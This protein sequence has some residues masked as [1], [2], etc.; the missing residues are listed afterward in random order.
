MATELLSAPSVGLPSPAARPPN[1]HLR[2]HVVIERAAARV[3]TA[4]ETVFA[5]AGVFLLSH[6]L[7]PLL[8]EASG[9]LGGAYEG[10]SVLRNQFAAI[11]AMSLLLLAVHAKDSIATLGR[12]PE[13]AALV[14]LALASTQWSAAPDITL[15]RAFA[16]LG[17]TAFG[18][19]LASRFTPRALLRVLAAAFGLIALAS[20]AFAIGVPALGV[21]HGTHAG[22]WKGVYTHKNSLGSAMVVGGLVFLLLRADLPHGRRP[23]ATAGLA[24][25]GFLLL[26]STSKTALSL[27]L[28]LFA[29][30]ALFSTMRWR[31]DLA[32]M[33]FLGAVLVGG[34]VAMLLVANWEALLT[35]MGKDPSLTGRVPM[36]E[37]LVRTVGERPW[38]GYGYNAFW[39]GHTGP[40][41]QPLREIG[42]DTPS[43][44][45]G[46]L[47]VALQVGLVGLGLLLAGYVSAFRRGLAGL[48]RTASPAGLWPVLILTMVLLYNVTESVLLEKNNLTWALYVAA[49]CS[50][51]LAHPAA[52][53]RGGWLR[54]QRP[55]PAG[56]PR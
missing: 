20:L 55:A 5:V 26:M 27:L 19:F 3:F 42:W 9:S 6:A 46:F 7:V 32:V 49:V 2:R 45:N 41:A 13:L 39:L 48:R 12:R 25:C 22:A 51:L 10:N 8:L 35:A 24:L 1:P 30:A 37:V 15:R 21:D 40:S 28:I 44:H 31:M 50:P 16:L 56:R 18:V 23:L 34:S 52:T 4:T 14:I 11:H 54:R 43:A 36:W 47:E 53:G 33:V 38:L 17:T 29:A